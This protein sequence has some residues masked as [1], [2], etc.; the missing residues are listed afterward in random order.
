MLKEIL[1]WGGLLF[2][3]VWIYGPLFGVAVFCLVALL[4]DITYR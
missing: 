4:A 2:F 1:G 3:S